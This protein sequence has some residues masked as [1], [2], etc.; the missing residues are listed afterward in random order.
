MSELS[1]GSWELL[2]VV[3]NDLVPP[4][5]IPPKD[6]WQCLELFVVATQGGWC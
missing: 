1:V 5:P 3:L 4:P 2:K 6:I